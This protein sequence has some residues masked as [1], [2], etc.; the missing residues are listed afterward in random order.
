MIL[1]VN[2]DDFI[3]NKMQSNKLD[4]VESLDDIIEDALIKY[5]NISISDLYLNKLD[6][7]H[8]KIMKKI[9]YNYDNEIEYYFCTYAHLDPRKKL[10][11]ILNDV[12]FEYEPFYIGQGSMQR[13]YYID[14]NKDIIYHLRNL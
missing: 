7:N 3:F 9:N 12:I 2:I 10:N 4:E 1:T 5:L 14:R 13:A 11:L 6:S 8:Y